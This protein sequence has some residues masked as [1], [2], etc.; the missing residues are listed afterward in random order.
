MLWPTGPATARCTNLS[1][2]SSCP[3][4]LGCSSS[5]LPML[6][7]VF[8][9]INEVTVIVLLSLIAGKTVG[10]TL[11]SEAAV[12]LGFPLPTGMRLKHLAV[13]GLIA[14]IGLTV[15]LFVAGK[16][17][18]GPPFEDPAKMGAVLSGGVGLLAL[19]A[20]FLLRVRD[21]SGAESND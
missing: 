13:A 4:T 7:C 20:G 8:A 21:D 1:I 19:I 5:L 10:I 2:S 9:S 18:T 12:K 3:L 16:A 17:F 14:G 6:G 15:A 11:F